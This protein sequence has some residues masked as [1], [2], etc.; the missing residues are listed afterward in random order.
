MLENYLLVLLAIVMLYFGADWLV[1]G[2]SSLA[3]R[4]GISP[5]VIGLTVVAFGTSMPEMVV[6]VNANLKGFGGIAIGNVLGSNI[7]NICIILGLASLFNPLNVKS[8]IIKI[9]TPVMIF[10]AL[11][12]MLFFLDHKISRIEAIIFFI[13]FIS[14][15][16]FTVVYSKRKKDD[17]SIAEFSSEFKKTSKSWQLDIVYIALGLIVLIFGSKFLVDSSVAIAK[18]FN[19]SETIIG[20]TIIAAGTSMPELATSVVAAI[21][22]ESDISI[23]NVIGSNIFNLIAILDVS[24]LINPII[25]EKIS[26]V[27]IGMVVFSSI[28]LLPLMKT[29][30]KIKRWE[31]ILLL[32]VYGAYLF[33]L[34]PK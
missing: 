7:F 22:K 14:Y 27:D 33:Y 21:K 13:L 1:K 31:G 18:F 3:A 28:L 30:L 26:K 6:S 15:N 4:L 17:K 23:G 25:S 10:V 11:L 34:W 2:S 32:V 29:S 20:L 8:Q 5:L 12:F 16:V 9:D 24:G 19:I